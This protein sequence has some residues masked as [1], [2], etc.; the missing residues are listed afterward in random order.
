MKMQTMDMVND[1]AVV[2]S[3]YAIDFGKCSGSVATATN[4]HINAATGSVMRRETP[5]TD[6]MHSGTVMA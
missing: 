6:P 4:N 1:A 2:R 5:N 3:R